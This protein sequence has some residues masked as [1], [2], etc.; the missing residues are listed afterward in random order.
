MDA[1]ARRFQRLTTGG[2][3]ESG[4]MDG[5]RLFVTAPARLQGGNARWR[6]FLPRSSVIFWAAARWICAARASFW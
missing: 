5:R 3:G 2:A 4:R 6:Y 1:F